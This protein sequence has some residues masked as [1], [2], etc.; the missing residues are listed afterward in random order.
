M[1]L[2]RRTLLTVRRSLKPWLKFLMKTFR[3]PAQASPGQS[4]A[5]NS[6]QRTSSQDYQGLAHAPSSRLTLNFDR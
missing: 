5:N 2:E 3:H 1:A 4:L 6:L